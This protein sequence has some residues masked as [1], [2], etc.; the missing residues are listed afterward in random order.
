MHSVNARTATLRDLIL[1]ASVGLVLTWPAIWLGWPDL[2]H[3]SVNHARWVQQF[4]DQLRGGEW[5]PRWLTDSNGR[6]GSPMFFYYPPLGY[7]LTAP[8]MFLWPASASAAWHC[9]GVSSALV[10]VLSGIIAYFWM[11]RWAGPRGALWGA[12][13]YM[14]APWHTAVDLYN[15]GTWSALCAFLWMPLALLGVEY[16][17][18]KRRG[19]LLLTAVA[20]SLLVLSHMPSA[21][22]LS[23]VM[24]A[25]AFFLGEPDRRMEIAFQ[26]C[27]AIALGIG[28]TAVHLLPA[29]LL[30]NAISVEILG[31]KGGFYDYRKWFLGA[32]IHS[33]LDYKMRLL[34]V[35]VS[36][37]AAAG[38]A[39]IISRSAYARGVNR[40]RMILWVSV[41]AACLFFM[42]PLSGFL[43]A[44]VGPLKTLSQPP[45]FNATLNLAVAVLCAGAAPALY[46][47]R[48]RVAILLACGFGIAWLVGTEW[49]A[50][51]AFLTWRSDPQGVERLRD[52]ERLKEERYEY[53][54][55]WAYSAKRHG[56]EASLSVLHGRELRLESNPNE[57]PGTAS[58]V[59]WKPRHAVLNIETSQP[60]HLLVGQFYYP[61]WQAQDITDQRMLPISP[62]EPD[63]F[64]SVEVPAG[65]HQILLQLEILPPERIGLM[66]SAFSCLLACVSGLVSIFRRRNS[67][68][69]V[70]SLSY[71]D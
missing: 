13:V 56:V 49:A 11:A 58:V 68:V 4:A 26:T 50:S 27:Y 10:L 2:G 32:D 59:S 53:Q 29:V 46:W 71:G 39:Y 19:A 70:A 51:R 52:G 47:R 7:Y 16:L 66:I 23:P 41:S 25:Y 5:Y 21:M 8:L 45:R 60:T 28:L 34:V 63:G 12:I 14:L 55:R 18:E 30:Q 61:G 3:D 6:L 65:K 38:A 20:Y 43:W 15:A 35:T 64:I 57:Q 31:A 36:M 33:I 44:T 69:R 24:V 22:L 9:L 1:I 67:A 42:T 48:S 40:T 54:P 37:A 17:M 62:S